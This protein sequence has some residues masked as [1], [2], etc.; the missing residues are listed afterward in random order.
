LLPP[1]LLGKSRVRQR[2]AETMAALVLPG[3]CQEVNLEFESREDMLPGWLGLEEQIGK[4]RGVGLRRADG[5]VLEIDDGFAVQ[6]TWMGSGQARWGESEDAGRM[7][8]MR[9]HTKRLCWRAR[10]P[11]REYM[12]YDFLDCLNVERD[13]DGVV[14]EVKRLDG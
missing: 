5:M 1:P 10:V 3:S 13:K 9:Y 2:F 11:R 6:Y 8:K 14:K 7:E 12:S 4:C